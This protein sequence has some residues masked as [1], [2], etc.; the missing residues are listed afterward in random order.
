GI[1]ESQP[2]QSVFDLAERAKRIPIG[3]EFRCVLGNLDQLFRTLNLKRRRALLRRETQTDMSVTNL[4]IA[5]F[6]R[7]SVEFD[8]FSILAIALNQP[9]GALGNGFRKFRQWKH[10]VHKTPIDRALTFDPFSKRHEDV[11][12]IAPNFSLIDQPR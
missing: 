8:A 3:A 4:V 11:R 2:Q 5:R 12:A 10:A 6:R 1:I 9:L 7:K